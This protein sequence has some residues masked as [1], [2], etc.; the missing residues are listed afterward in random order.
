MEYD[1]NCIMIM[2]CVPARASLMYNFVC[3][4]SRNNRKKLLSLPLSPRERIN[5][6]LYYYM[7]LQFSQTDKLLNKLRRR[8]TLD[9]YVTDCRRCEA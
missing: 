3:L 4:D 9:S 7:S 2:H 6:S 5:Y 1:I 8:D